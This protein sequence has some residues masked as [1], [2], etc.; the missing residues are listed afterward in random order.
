VPALAEEVPSGAA[1]AGQPAKPPA[2]WSD[3]RLPPHFE[4][5]VY[6]KLYAESDANANAHNLHPAVRIF[7]PSTRTAN[8]LGQTPLFAGADNRGRPHVT[9]YFSG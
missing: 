2:L 3:H 4:V 8:S 7:V 1:C 9:L 6:V 5:G